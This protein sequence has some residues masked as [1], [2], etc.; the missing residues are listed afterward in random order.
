MN[1]ETS[2]DITKA[3][4]AFKQGG[5]FG[6]KKQRSSN[7]ELYRI[8]CMMMIVA[9]H[10]VV[11][12]GLTSEGGSLTMDLTSGNSLF[13]TLFGAWGKTGINC[14][15]MITGYF[16][17]TSIITIRKFVKLMGQ[18]YFYKCFFFVVFLVLGYETMAPQRLIKLVMPFW[19]ITNGFVSCFIAFWLT[20]PFWTILVRNMNQRQHQL[21]LLLLFGIYTILGS[22]PTFE[23]K[24]N[25]VTW[26]GI[27]FLISSYI[28]LY[29]HAIFNRKQ[30]WGVLT[31]L[32][33]VF[34]MLSI[35]LMRW[36][37][38]GNDIGISYFFVSDCN[39]FFAVIVAV[40]SFLWFKNMSIK[41]SK[42]I[43]S[44]GAAT[45]GVLL[46]HANSDAMRTWLWQDLVDVAGHYTLHIDD[47]MIYSITVVLTIFVVCNLIDQ[48]RIATL[49]KWF[50][51]WYD[52]NWTIKADAWINKLTRNNQ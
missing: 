46:I 35:V 32:S 21:L 2:F 15:M 39:S 30:L 9:H 44:F 20:I 3:P 25:Y 10:Y 18:I 22:V 11:N 43:N 31:L 23:I 27:L 34:A 47:L 24:Y 29:P 14:F 4:T 38:G 26:F 33:V 7:L 6:A 51:R 41:Y 45:F 48:L 49:E 42:I 19:N 28:R 17:C 16:M 52:S 37:F 13:L 50:F 12:S 5:E 36:K 40:C 8:I 1:E